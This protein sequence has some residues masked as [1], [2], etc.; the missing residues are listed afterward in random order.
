M[1]TIFS[2]SEMLCLD[3][4]HKTLSAYKSKKPGEASKKTSQGVLEYTAFMVFQ[5]AITSF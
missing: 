5:K 2:S 1:M 4:G 3:S